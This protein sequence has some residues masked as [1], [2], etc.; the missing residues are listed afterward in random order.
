MPERKTSDIIAGFIDRRGVGPRTIDEMCV[1][2]NRLH[3]HHNFT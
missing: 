2:G 1:Q 3:D